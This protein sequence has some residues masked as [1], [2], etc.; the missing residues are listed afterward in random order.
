PGSV[1]VMEDM[2]Q[3]HLLQLAAVVT[4]DAP[5]SLTHANLARNRLEA[6]RRL[7]ADATSENGETWATLA[8]H[9]EMARWRETPFVLRAAKGAAESRRYVEFRLAAQGFV[10]LGVLAGKLVI[11]PAGA[12]VPAELA[13]SSDP[14]S[15]S[16]R[17]LR[18]ALSGDD[19]FTLSPD[20]PVEAWRIVEGF[21]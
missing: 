13:L 4:M 6:L 2:I 11:A 10:R 16:T 14:E 15:A 19:T 8:V 12:E 18:A 20:E 21:D 3:S 17:L 7:T 1:G 5:A 9:S